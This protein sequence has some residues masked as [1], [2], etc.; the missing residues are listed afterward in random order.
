MFLEILD[1]K[2]KH[3]ANTELHKVDTQKFKA[4]QYNHITGTY[5]KKT[6]KDRWAKLGNGEKV[7]RDLYSAFL[8]MNS[9]IDMEKTDQKLCE[10]TYVR[11]KELHDDEINRIM[12]DGKKHI[13]S[14]GIA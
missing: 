14:F 9:A 13:R 5:E 3:I 2:L 10:K 4:S 11:F 7:Q 12:K 6:L 8:L 1:K